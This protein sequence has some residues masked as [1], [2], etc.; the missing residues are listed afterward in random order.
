MVNTIDSR[1]GCLLYRGKNRTANLY[2]FVPYM[3]R[4]LEQTGKLR[5]RDFEIVVAEQ[6]EGKLF[7]RGALLN[8]GYLIARNDCD[9]VSLHDVDQLPEN[10][11]NTYDFPER[12]THQCSA[13]SQF[14]YR[15]AYSTMV[16]GVL[17][18]SNKHFEM[19]NG[20]SNF[21][22]GWGQEDDDLYYRLERR[23][24][25]FDR[26]PPSIGRYRASPHP[27]VKDLDVTP[28][29]RL[30]RKHLKETMRGEH[31]DTDGLNSIRFH[32][33]RN[34]LVFPGFRHAT[35]EFAFDW[36]PEKLDDLPPGVQI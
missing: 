2:E 6:T 7:N 29:F 34:T 10:P 8:A 21:Y 22:W 19:L 15:P 4:F 26:L 27:R 3:I 9:Y 12:P 14:N 36:M 30:G 20:F 35:V 33:L 13:S 5:G 32:V 23:L 17:L 28:L 16:G 18:V 1:N 11:Q 24:R 25:N 31:I